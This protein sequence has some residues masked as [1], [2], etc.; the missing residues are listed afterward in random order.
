MQK[1]NDKTLYSASDLVSFMECQ[2]LTTLDIINL[3]T[4]LEKTPDDEQRELITQKGDEHEA[5]YLAKLESDGNQVVNIADVAGNIQSRVIATERAMRNGAQVIYQAALQ[6]GSYIGLLD[7]IVRI[8]GVPSKYGNYSYEAQDTKLARTARAKAIIQLTYYS[9]LLAH[10]Q[11]IDPVHLT[12]VLGNNEHA[13]FRYADS[14]RYFETL[15][16]NFEAHLAKTPEGRDTYPDPKEKCGQCHWSDRCNAQR[17]ADDH[18]SQVAGITKQNI[19]RLNQ[20]GIMTMRQLSEQPERPESAQI[21]PQTY[22]KVHLQALLQQKGKD[23]GERFYEMLADDENGVRGFFRLP[24]PNEGDM[25]FDME[26]NPLEEGGLEYL[27]GIYLPRNKGKRRF[28]DFWAHDRAQ[29][30]V[31]FEKFVDF[32]TRRLKRYPNAHIYHYAPYEQT[33]MKKLMSVHGTREAQIDNLLRMGKFIDLYQVVREGIRVSEPRYSIKNIEKFYLDKRTVEVTNAGASIVYYERWKATQDPKLLQ[34]I[35]DYNLDDVRSTYELLLWLLNIRREHQA[36]IAA[37]AVDV[38]DVRELAETEDEEAEEEHS[39]ELGEMTEAEKRLVPY[40]AALVAPAPE[41]RDDWTAKDR[42]NE[43]TYQLLDFHRREAKPEWWAMFARREASAEEL[44]TDAECLAGLVF[45]ENVK[46]EL[47]ARSVRYTYN[48][49]PQDTKLRTGSP[50]S[51]CED[52]S[53]VSNLEIFPDENRVTFTL[54]RNRERPPAQLNLGP[55]SPISSKPMV[56]ALFRYASSQLSK[57]PPRYP[58]VEAFLARKFPNVTT[59]TPGMPLVAEDAKDVQ[60]IVDTVAGMD[61]TYMFLQGPPGAGKT[62]TG[63][64]VIV[65]LLRRGFKV[66]ISSNSHHAIN[67]LLEAVEKVAL[68]QTV[69]VRGIKK[70]N[71]GDGEYQSDRDVDQSDPVYITNGYTNDYVMEFGYNLLAGTAWLFSHE[72]MDQQLDY[73]FIDEAGQV[74]LANLVAM[75]TCTK[76]LVLLGDQMQLAQP[77]KGIHPGISGE[78]SLDYLLQGLSTIPPE[79]GI[80]LKQTFRMHPDVCQFISEAVYDGRLEANEVTHGQALVLNRTAHPALRD[81]GISYHPVT[82]VGCSQDSQEEAVEVLKLVDNLLGQSFIDKHGVVQPMTL[83]NIL[84]VA[85]Y[86]MQVNRL[87]QIL[88]HNARVGTVDK[89]QGQEAEVVIVSMATSNEDT[90]PRNIE[91]LFSKNRLNVAISRAKT[92]AIMVASPQLTTIP[93]KTPHQ[94]N[95]VNTMCWVTSMTKPKKVVD[96]AKRV[97]VPKGSVPRYRR[98]RNR[99]VNTALAA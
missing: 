6:N 70:S 72:D 93:C 62:Y 46:P 97:K 18:L 19:I 60:A 22:T 33:A 86:N 65:D 29:E 98:I 47:V 23:T 77:S 32:V 74:S 59:V 56:E 52:G 50:A 64:H 31:A 42:I 9:W 76:N 14:V 79:K 84:V 81:S 83:D 48:Y 45:D 82:H 94:L 37:E 58:A 21:S 8:D 10:A 25:F 55:G 99:N 69:S 57:E 38:V 3:E 54:G 24:E 85:P 78:S 27:F 90:M 13:K 43:L 35:A 89:F 49:P 36:Q 41:N 20:V 1:R 12:I 68:K 44:M 2:H 30:K 11:G 39:Y 28:K 73:L 88:P 15:K 63:S 75:G 92:L 17:M 51:F 80:F 26:G 53:S 87:K 40:H 67:N 61:H 5:A 16:T 4:P 95:L 71:K 34:D 7:F 91:F 66:G 96:K